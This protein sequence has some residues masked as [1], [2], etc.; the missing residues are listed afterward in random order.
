MNNRNTETTIHTTD[1]H[2][3]LAALVRGFFLGFTEGII[4][5]NDDRETAKPQRIKQIML[6][7]YE[8]IA[9]E[10]H[11]NMFIPIANINYSYEE[12]IEK[13]SANG[14]DFSSLMRIA[15]KTESLY[16]AMVDEYKMNFQCLLE[17]RIMPAREYISAYTR[18]NESNDSAIATDLAVDIVTGATARSYICGLKKNAT[19]NVSINQ[20]R[21][22]R[23]VMDVINV[24]LNGCNEHEELP[25][26]TDGIF[27]I[28]IKACRTRRNMNVMLE[29]INNTYRQLIEEE[30]ISIRK[31]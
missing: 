3:V 8:E 11:A 20:P 2:T 28:M 24:L 31:P 21:L 23:I 10:F 1:R 26:D 30:D 7:H 6:N 27:R 18:D 9:G 22:Y 16:K 15:C 17:G 4:S 19:G 12:I 14:N 5:S 25:D 13:V 29:S